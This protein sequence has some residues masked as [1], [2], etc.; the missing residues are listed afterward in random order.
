MAPGSQTEVLIEGGRRIQV[1]CRS[2]VAVSRYT[3]VEERSTRILGE[4]RYFTRQ[5][6]S[7]GVGTL[8]VD[9]SR[10]MICQGVCWDNK[11]AV[12]DN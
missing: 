3:S 6:A 8:S 7:V 4:R 1:T 11:K 12:G 9:D 10:M 2:R 5:S